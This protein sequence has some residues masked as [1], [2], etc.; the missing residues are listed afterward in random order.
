ME[1]EWLPYNIIA[2]YLN[3]GINHVLLRVFALPKLPHVEREHIKSLPVTY[4]K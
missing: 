4:N 2:G 1:S 3:K